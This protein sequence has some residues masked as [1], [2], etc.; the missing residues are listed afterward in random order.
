MAYGAT[1][2]TATSTSSRP[3]TRTTS[4]DSPTRHLGAAPS[5]E[6]LTDDDARA[7]PVQLSAEALARIEISTWSSD[8]GDFDVL[9]DMPGRGGSRHG[10]VELL[11][12]SIETTLTA[13]PSACAALA[14]IIASKEFAGRPKDHDA[15]P[16]LREIAVASARRAG[17][18]YSSSS[19][20]A[21]ALSKMRPRTSAASL[22]DDSRK[23]L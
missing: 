4:P 15:L 11:P 22:S 13:P 7:L 18:T 16:E 17:R 2:P 5:G 3:A 14:D 21:M 8:A 19:A 20:G 6:G 23:W 12:R 1:R 10:Y 9:A